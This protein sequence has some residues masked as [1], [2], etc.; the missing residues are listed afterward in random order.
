MD[1]YHTIVK[2][3]EKIGVE[4]VF[5]GSGQVNG[6][7]LLALNKIDKIKTVIIQNEQ[8]SSFMATGYGMFSNK[9]GVCFAT[10]EQGGFNLF[11]G[12]AV[13]YSDSIPMLAISGYPSRWT[14][15]KG[16]LNETSRLSRTPD[17]QKMFA[18]TTKK[19]IVLEDAKARAATLEPMTISTNQR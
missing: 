5:G 9:L 16:A 7:M 8:A 14:R 12:L 17:S 2:V 19:S 11:S 13:A 18:S 6:S 15:G 3:P 1:V 4:H 10:G